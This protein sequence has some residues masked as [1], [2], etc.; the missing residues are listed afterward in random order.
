MDVLDGEH[1][2]RDGGGGMYD[3]SEQ[4]LAGTSEVLTDLSPVPC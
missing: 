2:V 3:G 1:A 4:K